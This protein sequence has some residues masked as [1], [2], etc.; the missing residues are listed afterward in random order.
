MSLWVDKYR[1]NTLSKLDYH[2]E[3]AKYLKKLVCYIYSYVRTDTHVLVG[4]LGS[5]RRRSASVGVWSFRSRQ[6]DSHHVHIKGNVRSRSRKVESGAYDI[7]SK[8]LYFDH[9]II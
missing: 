4:L 8:D 2:Q 1:P 3:Q 9:V 7:H 6:E 5:Q